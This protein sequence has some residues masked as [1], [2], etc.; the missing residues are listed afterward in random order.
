M[1]VYASLHRLG[2]LDIN[3]QRAYNTSPEMFSLSS[4]STRERRTMY[5]IRLD[6]QLLASF[7]VE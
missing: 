2:A 4:D 6:R 1:C 3:T 7:E 5:I